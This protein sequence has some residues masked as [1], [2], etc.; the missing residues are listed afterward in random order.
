MNTNDFSKEIAQLIVD[1][2]SSD[3]TLGSSLFLGDLPYDTEGVEIVQSA[4]PLPDM[5]TPIEYRQLDFVA[6]Y[7]K[8]N[9]AIEK[10]SK[11]Y[12]FLHQNAHYYTNTYVIHF[13]HATGNIEDI[14]RDIEGRKLMRI[15]IL[16]IINSLIS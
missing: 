13:S 1:E 4:S 3:F 15:S 7:K 10:L 2:F 8:T 6:R 12:S 5:E 14:D 11:I 16:F 9:T